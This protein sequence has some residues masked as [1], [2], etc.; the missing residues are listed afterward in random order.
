MARNELFSD[1]SKNPGKM[2]IMHNIEIT[3]LANPAHSES[4]ACGFKKRSLAKTPVQS[5]RTGNID[6]ASAITIRSIVIILLLF[7]E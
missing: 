4:T 1:R 5:S 7:I 2:N 3:T 6:R